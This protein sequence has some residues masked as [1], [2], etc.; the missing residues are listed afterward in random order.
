MGS[1]KRNSDDRI[2][3]TWGPEGRRS[4]AKD[5]MVWGW[6]NEQETDAINYC[7]LPTRDHQ[8]SWR[9][10]YKHHRFKMAEESGGESW[11]GAWGTELLSNVKAKS[12]ETFSLVKQDLAEFVTTIQHDTTVTVAETANTVKEKL[13]VE[14][15]ETDGSTTAV[16]RQGVSHWLGSL[17]TALKENVTQMTAIVD[18]EPA[19]THPGPVFDR[20]QA[21]VHEIQTD[22]ATYCNDPDGHPAHYE[23]WCRGFDLEQHKADISE[24]LVN[25]PEIRSLY[26]KLVPS[27]VTNSLFWTRYFYKMHRFHQE[28]KRKAAL[29]ERANKMDEE[30]IGWD[31]EE[32]SWDIDETYLKDNKPAHH[33]QSEAISLR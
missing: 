19:S 9:H 20:V 17:S 30:D 15:D 2:E 25:K 3:I 12:A 23:D 21:R 5:N 1:Y 10:Q 4:R 31:D 27:A 11:W 24:L 6:K 22:P 7:T 33:T 8:C 32:E 14:E 13:K 16:I 28:E 26:T 29:V 18:E